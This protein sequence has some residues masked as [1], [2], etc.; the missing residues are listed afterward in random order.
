MR[1][2]GSV[3]RTAKRAGSQKVRRAS[4]LKQKAGRRGRKTARRVTMFKSTTWYQTA[5]LSIGISPRAA[6]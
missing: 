2:T 1:K 6:T 4:P 3:S 5:A